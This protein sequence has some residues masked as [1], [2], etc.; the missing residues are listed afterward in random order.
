M[1]D[2]S[3]RRFWISAFCF[4]ITLC[5]K[6]VLAFADVVML[7]ASWEHSSFRWRLPKP[8]L[9]LVCGDEKE[10]NGDASDQMR[11]LK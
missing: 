1:E 8:W 5:K 11:D 9:P 10:L 4:S 3:A 7:A 2:F 6:I